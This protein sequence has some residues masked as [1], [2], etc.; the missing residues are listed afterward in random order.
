MKY[1][2]LTL[3]IVSNIFAAPTDSLTFKNGNFIVGEIKSMDRG[4][5]VIETSYSDSDFEIEW[6]KV[7]TIDTETEF[8]VTLT[9]GRKYY[10]RL[11][12]ASDL[13]INILTFDEQII[14]CELNDIVWLDM[15][16]HGF[17]D[18]LSASIEVSFNVTSASHLRKFS[19]RSTIGYKTKKWS[20]NATFNSFA[21]IQD[22]VAPI[23]RS[24]GL[25]SFRYILP[26][27]LYV[28]TTV[29][30]E[31]DTDKK[32]D[33][34]MNAQIGLGKF[35]VRTNHS[36]WGTKMGL[37]RNVEKYTN[38]TEDRLTWEGYFGSELNLYD[39]GDL[40]LLTTIMVYPGITALGRWRS[41]FNLDIKYDLPLDFY[42]KLGGTLNYDNRPAE[43]ANKATYVLETGF[44][45]EW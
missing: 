3:V 23:N 35:F 33:L 31:S 4:V 10:G 26:Y 17:W 2:M 25:I 8:L 44:G 5:V 21:S 30:L 41:D 14:E 43:G 19:T 39:I 11:I 38:E 9:D 18:Q 42:I 16:E 36:Y 37:N 1:L 6:D 34:R 32:L 7:K 12:S 29:S 22:T 13:T 28:I 27:R 45:W 20:T 40:N 24:D 15:V